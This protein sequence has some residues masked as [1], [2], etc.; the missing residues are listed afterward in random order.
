MKNSSKILFLDVEDVH[1]YESNPRINDD[2]VEAVAASIA[3]FGFRAPIIVDANHVIIAGHTR[4]KAAKR[5]GMPKVPV[6]IADDLSEEQVRAYRLADNKTG[7]LAE[8]DYDLLDVE[9]DGILDID[10]TEFGFEDA[11]LDVDGSGSEWVEGG[12][13]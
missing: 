6:V 12:G 3:E 13:L 11:D 8:W 2:A 5:L 4:L 7:E 10:M 1:P 9:L